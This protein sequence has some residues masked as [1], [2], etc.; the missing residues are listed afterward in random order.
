[1]NNLRRFKDTFAKLPGENVA[2]SGV[3]LL[4][5]GAAGAW[6]ADRVGMPA[7]TMI[8]ALVAS[9]AYRL[10]GGA[11][12]P[13]RKRYGRV[14][15]LLLG[16]RLNEYGFEALTNDIDSVRRHFPPDVVIDRA[17]LE[18]IMFYIKKGDENAVA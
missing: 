7:G 2:V 13:W 3:L 1:M 8:G 12:G 4:V 6:L 15:R 9:G 14:G 5:V 11:V 10:A 17:S 18:D 16:T